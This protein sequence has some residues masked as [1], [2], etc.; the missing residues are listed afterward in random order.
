MTFNILEG[1]LVAQLFAILIVFARFGAALMFMPAFGESYIY[2]RHRL[3]LALGI[4]LV[5]APFLEP[6]LPSVPKDPLRLS[7]LLAGEMFIGSLYGLVARFL[8]S[9][10]HIAGMIISYQSSLALATQ[11]D[12]TQAAQGSIVGN[13]LTMFSLVLI[14][15]FDLHHMLLRGV[16][17]SYTLMSPTSFPPMED[18]ADYMGQLINR[19]FRVGVQLAAPSIVAGLLLYLA[20]GILSRLMPNMQVFFVI[21]PLQ[22]LLSFFVLMA[23]IVS[24]FTEWTRFFAGTYSE[25]LEGL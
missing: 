16:A 21:M 3:L 22:I 2:M 24:I 25:F 18:I 19:I 14:F 8:V 1:Y 15:T 17:D 7:Y 5:M 12:T 13:M 6:Y 9:T 10:M 4:A 23:V 11:F 20:A